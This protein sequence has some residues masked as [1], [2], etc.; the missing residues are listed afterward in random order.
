M[1]GAHYDFVTGAILAVGTTILIFVVAS[2]IP[3]GP[4]G[5]EGLH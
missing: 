3:D 1:L 2:I 4:A 5:K